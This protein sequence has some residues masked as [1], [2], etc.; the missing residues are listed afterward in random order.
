MRKTR[1]SV[2]MISLF[3]AAIFLLLALPQLAEA[4]SSEAPSHPEMKTADTYSR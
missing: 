1:I 2:G 3:F 4:V